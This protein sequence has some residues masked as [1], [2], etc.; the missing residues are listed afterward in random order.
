[1]EKNNLFFAKNKSIFS[2]FFIWQKNIL[3]IF[4]KMLKNVS[5]NFFSC[6]ILITSRGGL[7][8]YPCFV[9]LSHQLQIFLCLL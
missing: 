1:M 3:K 2:P 9:M 5:K 8:C 7:L 4:K 6:D